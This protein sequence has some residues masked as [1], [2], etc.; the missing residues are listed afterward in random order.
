ML[1]FIVDELT[2][3]EIKIPKFYLN[4]LCN[5]DVIQIL[6]VQILDVM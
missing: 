3:F 1:L 2:S 6:N 5:C 4:Q